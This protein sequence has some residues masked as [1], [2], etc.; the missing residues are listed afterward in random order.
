MDKGK[1][2]LEN[3][4]WV[5]HDSVAYL[6]PSPTSVNISNTV[7]TGNWRQINHQSWATED[8][9][10]KETFTLWIDHGN[11]PQDAGYS[12]IGGPGIDAASID[13]YRK[14]NKITILSNTNDLQAVKH[15]S[16]HISFIV[17]YK[18]GS[19]RITKDLLLSADQ[20]CIVMVKQSGN[21][22]EKMADSEPTQK[23][24]ALQF[25]GHLRFPTFR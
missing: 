21:G 12:Y 3:V 5:Y 20:P 14:K 9:V 18:R 2:R 10:Q 17:F 16:L 1:H 6:F 19:I 7:A 8:P 22:I 11:K 4:S 25:T 23:L 13:N 15:D 24:T